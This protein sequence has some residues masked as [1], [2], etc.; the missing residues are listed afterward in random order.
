MKLEKLGS[1][2]QHI[3]LGENTLL[4]SLLKM[5]TNLEYNP[6]KM[7]ENLEG[8]GRRRRNSSSQIQKAREEP[9]FLKLASFNVSEQKIGKKMKL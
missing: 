3:F 6:A 9:E 1:I 5:K 8:L 7:I 2:I 4:N